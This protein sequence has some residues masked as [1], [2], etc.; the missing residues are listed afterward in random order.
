MANFAAFDIE[1]TGL[2]TGNKD[3]SKVT[4]YDSCRLLSFG[5]V[6]YQEGVEVSC[7]EMIV[8]PIGFKVDATEIHGITEEKALTEG[9]EFDVIY[10]SIKNIF[11]GVDFIVGHNIKFDINCLNAE[12][13]RRGYEPLNPTTVCSQEMCRTVLFKNYRLGSAYKLLFTEELKNW[14]SAIP[15]ARASAKIYMTLKDF[16]KAELPPIAPKRITIKVSDIGKIIGRFYKFGAESEVLDSMLSKHFPIKFQE[17]NRE[18]QQRKIINRSPETQEIVEQV[19]ETETNT[20]DDV[21]TLFESFKETLS[22]IEGFS[23]YE[24]RE[25]NEYVRKILSTRHG[26]KNEPVTAEKLGDLQTDEKFYE[27]KIINISGT[28][29]VLCGRIDGFAVDSE[30]KKTL[31]EIK[32]RTK[33]LFNELR[34][35]EKAQVNCYLN[36]TEVSQ[37]KLVEMFNDSIKSYDVS[38]DTEDYKSYFPILERFC[39]AFHFTA[40]I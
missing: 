11:E 9:Y 17:Y 8:K 38:I 12:C 27:E 4:N 25:I 30:G 37:G 18:F 3:P 32:N 19:I 36:M 13:Y 7:L 28:R 10:N 29:Y 26:D 22:T 15:D 5:V 21:N 6:E 31:Y 20:S 35:Y 40:G 39:R 14:H 1:T 33:N 24:K 2:P 34:A 23:P 16:H